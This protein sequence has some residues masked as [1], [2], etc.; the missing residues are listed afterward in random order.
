M[1]GHIRISYPAVYDLNDLVL[2]VKAL[3]KR[4]LPAAAICENGNIK[5]EALEKV[6]AWRRAHGLNSEV[7]TLAVILGLVLKRPIE[8]SD[9]QS[10]LP[11]SRLSVSAVLAKKSSKIVVNYLSPDAIGVGLSQ[12]P[13]SD[14]FFRIL[15]N[16]VL[17]DY[18]PRTIQCRDSY[19]GTISLIE[20]E[21]ELGIRSAGKRPEGKCII[22]WCEFFKINTEKGTQLHLNKSRV[23]H[24]LVFCIK[25][26]LA[27]EMLIGQEHMF[28][29]M[30]S[31]VLSRLNLNASFPFDEVFEVLHRSQ[32]PPAFSFKSGRS[33]LSGAW[34]GRPDFSF[35]SRTSELEMPSYEYVESV[36][37]RFD[38]KFWG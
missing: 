27:S 20:L 25:R 1:V 7:I 30:R 14:L 3:L 8:H 37:D 28:A 9:Y 13:Q 33:S 6:S 10:M 23:C 16:H 29:E 31:L 21:K 36:A 5:R 12:R 34:K 35:F 2:L 18:F 4:S 24:Y 32:R 11:E 26:I 19:E 22:R 38:L 17:P 15:S